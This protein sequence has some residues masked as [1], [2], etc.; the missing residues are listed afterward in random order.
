MVSERL[1]DDREVSQR[2]SSFRRSDPESSDQSPSE[3]TLQLSVEREKAPFVVEI[4]S[5]ER[6]QH[7]VLRE[8]EAL[9]LG[10]GCLA[11]VRV[12]DRAVSQRHCRLRVERGRMVV[13]DLGSTNGLYVGGG[14]VERAELASGT[15]FVMGRVVVTCSASPSLA[16]IEDDLSI[17]PLAGVIAGSLAMRRVIREVR[18]LAA[19][20]GPVLFRGETGT[21]KDVLA[22]ALHASGPRKGRS[23]VALNVGALPRELAEAELFG[24]EK[25]AFTGAFAARDGAFVE[26]H[27]GTLFLDEIAELA[28]DLQVKLLRV[29][30]DFEVRRI[31]GRGSRKVDVR[32]ASATWAPLEERIEDGRFRLDL[33][34]RLAV[35]IIDVP[36]LRER[37]CDIVTLAEKTLRD[38]RDEVGPRELSSAAA[39]RLAAYRWPGNVRELRNVVYRAAVAAEGRHIRA[40]DVAES[41][42]VANRRSRPGVSPDEARAFIE[43][44]PSSVSAAARKLGVPRSTLRGWIRT[45]R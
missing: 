20:K 14:R 25:G 4:G 27:G 32:I 18:R 41:L 38:L 42:A 17:E 7:R 39:A 2:V 23:F 15:S 40:S 34:Q 19:I 9:V 31:G 44:N 6:S 37:R 8:G 43:R 36:P 33:F 28:P 3:A 45:S 21:G 16:E 10:S 35:F 29:L 26:A 1:H 12:E 30:E 22:R 24:H 11:D 5:S 13:E